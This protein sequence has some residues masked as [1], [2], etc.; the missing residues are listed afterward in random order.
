MQIE[1]RRLTPDL[2]E[3][4]LRFFDTEAHADNPDPDEHGCYCVCWCS[5]DHRQPVDFSTPEK[6]RELAAR[7]VTDG[8][9]QGYLAYAGGRVAGW[10]NA[11]DRSRCMNCVSW[12]MFMPPNISGDTEA[13]RVKSVFCFAIAPDMKRRG[14]ATR[15]L[16]RV[17]AD[18][19]A[20]GFDAV[21]A[22]PN[23]MFVNEF[24]DF[25]GP[26]AMYRKL[27]FTEHGAHKG[28]YR[29]CLVMR[30]KLAPGSRADRA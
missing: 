25:M 28:K 21:E 26:L 7:Y 30:R 19:E 2:L 1:I 18:A 24:K 15:L 3:D 5:A 4:Y 6:R 20:E 9:I 17:C 14:I 29:D 12:L 27:G 10:C 16:E 8:S 13:A 23:A 11:N 22:Y